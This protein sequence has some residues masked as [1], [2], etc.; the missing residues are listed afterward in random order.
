MLKLYRFIFKKFFKSFAYGIVVAAGRNYFGRICV[1]HKGGGRKVKDVKVDRY[2]YLNQFGFVFRIIKNFFCTGFLGLIIYDNGLCSFI[3]LSEGLS[4][5]AKIFSGSQKFL[6]D[7]NKN[8]S[9]QKL[10]NI[11]LF[12]NINS[13]E[14]FPFSGAKLS[15]AAGTS[16][17]IISKDNTKSLLKLSSGWLIRISNHSIG[18]LGL[19][20]NVGYCYDIIK[21]AGIMRS[22]GIRPTVRG[23]I[24]NPCDH[25]HGGGEG[26]GS[27][28]VAQV[29]PWGWLCKGT[30]SIIKKLFQ[31]II[32]NLY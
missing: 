11:N 17:K 10:L 20:S 29:S 5:G 8:G 3:L 19:V 15:R 25:P 4:K 9:S 26:K 30:P 7:F 22:N 1:Q 12:D 6:H 31:R 24:K 32:Q 28:P 16:A 2:R 14:L 21:K 13:I 18:S 23:V 27:P